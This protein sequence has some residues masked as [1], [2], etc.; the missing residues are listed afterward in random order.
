MTLSAAFL[1]RPFAHRGLHDRG[2]GVIENSRAAFDAAV[3][4]GYGIEL[5]VQYSAD[6]IPVVFH[7]HTLDRLT[8]GT[9]AVSAKTAMELGQLQLQGSTD[10]I[11]PLAIVLDRIDGRVPVLVEIKTQPTLALAQAVGE[12]LAGRN[13]PLA[14]MS[15]DPA[16]IHALDG[17]NHP[18]GLTT[19]A[20]TVQA[21]PLDDSWTPGLSFISHDHLTLD[22][23]AVTAAR[24]KGASVLCWT[25][26]S[27]VDADRALACADQ[28]TFEGFRPGP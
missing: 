9:G 24:S 15:F 3:A 8:E 12:V 17:L 5:D 22:H 1:S 16:S 6:G 10:T 20:D 13:A 23:P 27:Q 4:A 19:D 2:R 18:R 25:I 7:D 11:L 21:Y 14:A 26:R 28:I